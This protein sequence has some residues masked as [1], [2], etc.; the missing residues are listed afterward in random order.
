MPVGLPPIAAGR[1]LPLDDRQPAPTENH[2]DN[3]GTRAISALVP[4]FD[5]A[6]R[7]DA[8][9]LQAGTASSQDGEAGDG[10]GDGGDAG[11]GAKYRAHA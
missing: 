7:A 6:A 9:P 2:V 10:E 5:G 4:L 11:Q 1:R 8:E 3:V